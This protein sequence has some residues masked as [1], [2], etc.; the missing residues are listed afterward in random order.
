RSDL[1]ALVFARIIE[2]EARDS[3][4]AG[5]RDRL[6]R[7][8]GIRAD[9]LL[10]HPVEEVDDLLRVRGPFF[11]LDT[12]VEVFRVLSHDG[13]VRPREGAVTGYERDSISHLRCSFLGGR[14]FARPSLAAQSARARRSG[15]RPGGYFAPLGKMNAAVKSRHP[16][17]RRE[18]YAR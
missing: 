18:P 4:G 5:D 16:R 6:D 13:D 11:V 15:N 1:L 12:R 14:I 9:L 10:L 8:P 7:D 17:H 2:R 3:L